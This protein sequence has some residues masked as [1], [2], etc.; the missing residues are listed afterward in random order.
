MDEH[1]GMTSY[2]CPS[3][4]AT[5]FWRLRE[6]RDGTETGGDTGDNQG[7]GPL[8]VRVVV[9]RWLARQSKLVSITLTLLV[10]PETA[11]R[12]LNASLYPPPAHEPTLVDV[13]TQT[14]T[15]MGEAA[16]EVAA[17]LLRLIVPGGDCG[18]CAKFTEALVGASAALLL[19]PIVAPMVLFLDCVSVISALLPA[20]DINLV[21][22]GPIKRWTAGVLEDALGPTAQGWEEIVRP[23]DQL[24]VQLLEQ[25]IVAQADAIAVNEQVDRSLMSDE[26]SVD[27]VTDHEP[28]G[29][30]RT[31]EI[32]EAIALTA[33]DV[34][35]ETV[36]LLAEAVVVADVDPSEDSEASVKIDEVPAARSDV[37]ELERCLERTKRVLGTHEPNISG[38]GRV[39]G[40]RAF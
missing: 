2:A 33:D 34:A 5:I 28:G 8:R 22:L 26:W 19:H 7:Q 37:I 9:E 23:A 25:Q 16:G 40:I 36:E 24:A 4:Q 14:P 30:V 17:D 3:C 15:M 39:R 35:S 29:L 27:A 38:A 1:R 12:V 11:T 21:S 6:A 10:Q 32:G 18:L 20:G 13:V 31:P